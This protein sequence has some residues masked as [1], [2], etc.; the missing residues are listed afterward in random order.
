VP[1]RP[2]ARVVRRTGLGLFVGMVGGWLA[3]L[4]RAP[5]KP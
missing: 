3:G 2:T 1:S 4:L 5:K